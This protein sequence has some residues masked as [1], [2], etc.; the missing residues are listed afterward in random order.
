L[1]WM[2]AVWAVLNMLHNSDIITYLNS[3]TLAKPFYKL[4]WTFVS[5]C[6]F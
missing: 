1:K 4:I 3:L 5:F 2:R 6:I